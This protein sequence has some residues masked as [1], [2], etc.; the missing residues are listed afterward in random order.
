M[1]VR[2]RRAD[3]TAALSFVVVT[4]T[5]STIGQVLAALRRQTIRASI[6]LVAVCPDERM[7]GL[8]PAD[9]EGI[10]AV[11]VVEVGDIVPLHEAAAAGVRAATAPVVVIGETHA[12]PEPESLELVL[13]AFRDET[14]G[15]VAPGLRNAN[16]GAASWGSLMVTYG[17]ALGDAARETESISTHNAAV[18]RALLVALGD[19]LPF[20]LT[21]GGALGDSLRRD[22]YRL[23]YEPAAVFAHVNVTRLRSCFF[24]RFHSSRCYA[25]VRAHR[26]GVGRRALYAV[27][28]PLL[29]ALLG[30]RIVRS[31]GWEQHSGRFGWRVWPSIALSVTGMAAGEA[32][33]YA[34]GPGRS[35]ELV[36]DFEVHRERHA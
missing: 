12:F 7:L 32:A 30:F 35:F 20:R 1:A 5:V 23:L 22:G 14:V 18:R 36:A 8:A 6:E 19:E 10:G 13:R 15:A 27:G 21:L 34:R 3:L 26:W 33:A 9:V 28:A 2:D 31:P 29:P 24:D 11:R 16:P 4:D 17:S 25:S